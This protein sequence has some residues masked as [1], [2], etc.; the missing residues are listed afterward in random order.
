MKLRNRP[1]W[2][3]LVLTCITWMPAGGCVSDG[4]APS[5]CREGA[6]EVI[7]PGTNLCWKRCPI[8]Q[9]WTGTSC[10]G[11]EQPC[12]W[13]SAGPF[14]AQLGDGFRLPTKTEMMELLGGC[15]PPADD[16]ERP[17]Y[18][19]DCASSPACSEMFPGDTG[20]Y[21]TGTVYDPSA[22]VWDVQFLIGDIDN[23]AIVNSIAVRCVRT[24]P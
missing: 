17:V 1:G 10:S 4:D 23:G 19:D 24:A 8:G 12:G 20:Y 2:C 22:S 6:D 21:W 16:R 11:T 14:C 3:V 18:C 9:T 13:E 15:T 5:A 7:Q